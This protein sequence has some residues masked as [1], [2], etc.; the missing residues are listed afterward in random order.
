MTETEFYTQNQV[1]FFSSSGTGIS[2]LR[3]AG[4]CWCSNKII[5]ETIKFVTVISLILQLRFKRLGTDTK[6]HLTSKR[7][8]EEKSGDLNNHKSLIPVYLAFSGTESGFPAHQPSPLPRWNEFPW[9]MLQ[10]NDSILF[11]SCLGPGCHE[12]NDQVFIGSLT[13]LC[14]HSCTMWK[15]GKTSR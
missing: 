2:Y 3:N 8:R 15:Y 5:L 4:F 10:E 13:D 1:F 11:Y 12:E 9:I 6:L 14:G 7:Q